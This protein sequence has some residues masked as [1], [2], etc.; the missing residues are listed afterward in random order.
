MS[1]SRGRTHLESAEP[2][3]ENAEMSK[4]GSCLLSFAGRAVGRSVVEVAFGEGNSH[5]YTPG[6]CPDPGRT[7][8]CASQDGTRTHARTH[9]WYLLDIRPTLAPFFNL[10]APNPMNFPISQSGF[11]NFRETT[12]NHKTSI[13]NLPPQN[14]G[15]RSLKVA[16]RISGDWWRRQQEAAADARHAPS[17][18]PSTRR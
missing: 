17:R 16:W 6:W 15:E 8:L 1:L 9:A 10:F 11:A 12:L 2:A 4:T 7:L 13:P 5:G 14:P 18:R 3:E